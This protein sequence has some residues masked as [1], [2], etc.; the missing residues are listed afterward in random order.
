MCRQA[1]TWMHARLRWGQ[2]HAPCSSTR[3]AETSQRLCC[4]FKWQLAASGLKEEGWTVT[5][6]AAL[7]AVMHI[8]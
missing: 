5:P 2:N 1:A 6:A 7:A 3:T 4:S 8:F